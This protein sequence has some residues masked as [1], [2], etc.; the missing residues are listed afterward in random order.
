MM[1]VN[2]YALKSLRQYLKLSLRDVA[3]QTG[4][5]ITTLARIEEDH[6]CNITIDT[7]YRLCAAYGIHPSEVLEYRGLISPTN[8]DIIKMLVQRS[9]ASEHGVP[10]ET[11]L[12]I[13]PNEG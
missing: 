3:V 10:R 13:T 6:H 2:I 11:G 9:H 4:L 12:G 5:A 8:T 7:L 1:K